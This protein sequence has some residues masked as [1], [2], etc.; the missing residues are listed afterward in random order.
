MFS[1]PKTRTTEKDAYRDHSATG[2]DE[3]MIESLYKCLVSLDSFN[4]GLVATEHV[5]QAL[6][7]PP[8]H[9]Q[10]SVI[11]QRLRW[12]SAHRQET[13]KKLAHQAG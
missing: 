10:L 3:E 6:R 13:V 5:E 8:A 12:R 4:A 11:A 9:P 2:R 1:Y 7:I